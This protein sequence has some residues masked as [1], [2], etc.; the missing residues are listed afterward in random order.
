MREKTSWIKKFQ[1]VPFL[2]PISRLAWPTLL[3]TLRVT[4]CEN[5]HLEQCYLS[6]R[7]PSGIQMRR[8]SPICGLCVTGQVRVIAWRGNCE[9][10]RVNLGGVRKR[11]WGCNEAFL[12][13]SCLRSTSRAPSHWRASSHTARSTV[14]SGRS[15]RY[16]RYHETRRAFDTVQDN[17]FV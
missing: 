7:S 3:F 2:K 8:D 10:R 11:T 14:K 6:L 4:L 13:L 9:L 16:I 15:R 5:C 1:D 12:F 17:S